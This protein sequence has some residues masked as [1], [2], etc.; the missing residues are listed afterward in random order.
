LAP[1]IASELLEGETLRERITAGP[2]GIRRALGYALQIAHG[3][4]AAHAKNITHRDL[5]PENLGD[6]SGDGKRFLLTTP[7]GSTGTTPFTVVLNW[8]TALK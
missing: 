5:K 6:V 8:T 4:A 2:I 7:V 3:L 1:F